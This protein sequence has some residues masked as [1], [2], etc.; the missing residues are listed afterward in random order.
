[1]MIMNTF[2]KLYFKKNVF[3]INSVFL[4]FKNMN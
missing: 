3:I 1:M 2:T 4:N